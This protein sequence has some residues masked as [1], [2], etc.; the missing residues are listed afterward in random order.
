[1]VEEDIVRVDGSTGKVEGRR[2]PSSECEFHARIYRARRDVN[3]VIH[4]H[5]LYV[6]SLAAAH[7]SIPDILDEAVD[8]TPIPIIDYAPSG[9]SDLAAKAAAG[10]TK[11][12]NAVLLANHGIVVVGGSLEEAFER[13]VK[14]ERVSQVFVWAEA[15]GGAVPLEEGTAEKSRLVLRRYKQT[16]AEQEIRDPAEA[17]RLY[18]SVS[19]ADLMKFTFKSCVTFSS[20]LHT[21]LVQKLRR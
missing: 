12:C 16:R 21:L 2:R 20:L 15:L 19:L 3:A 17:L 5:S 18:E 8:L 10:I 1:M 9:S 6:T 11:G 14:V 7:K 4:H 13:S